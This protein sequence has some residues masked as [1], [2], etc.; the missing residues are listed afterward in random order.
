MV[1]QSPFWHGD[2]KTFKKQWFLNE[3]LL[4]NQWFFNGFSNADIQ[5]T[6]KNQWFLNIFLLTSKKNEKKWNAPQ[7][8]KQRQ[9]APSSIF[10]AKRW[11]TN[12]FSMIFPRFYQVWK[13]LEKTNWVNKK[14]EFRR[15]GYS[16]FFKPSSPETLKNQWFFNDFLVQKMFLL[17]NE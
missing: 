10:S 3:K 17:Q 16:I 8:K 12:G 14:N 2:R 7:K 1:L 4:K 5:K 9:K 6:L 13:P 11:K 15:S